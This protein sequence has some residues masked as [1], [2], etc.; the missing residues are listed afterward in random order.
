MKNRA[1]QQGLFK[2]IFAR[3]SCLNLLYGIFVQHLFVMYYVRPVGLSHRLH[4]NFLAQTAVPFCCV[5]R[6][7]LE[8]L[9]KLFISLGST[10]YHQYTVQVGLKENSSS[11]YLLEGTQHSLIRG[12]EGVLHPEVQPRNLS[13]TIISD[14]KGTTFARR[15]P[16]ITKWYHFYIPCLER[17]IP[18]KC[19]KC[20]VYFK[21]ILP[22]VSPSD[23]DGDTLS[24]L[25]SCFYKVPGV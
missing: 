20:A 10:E 13:N 21:N 7:F 17:C 12:W 6:Q 9:P 25:I 16:P 3:S 1:N 2:V 8:W 19:C 5:A 23:I 22:I 24:F 18:F 4:V 15:V 14:R 11:W